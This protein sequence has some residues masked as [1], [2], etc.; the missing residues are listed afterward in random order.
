M[1]TFA[2]G[3]RVI[4]HLRHPRLLLNSALILLL[5]SLLSQAQD[6]AIS[7][8][9]ATAVRLSQ[10][11]LTSNGFTFAD[12]KLPMC[13]ISGP[14]GPCGVEAFQAGEAN[15]DETRYTCMKLDQATYLGHCVNGKLDGL[16]LVIADGS[17]K[18]TKEAYIS[19]FDKGRIAYPALTSFLVGNT[20]FGIEEKQRSSGCVF[21]GKWDRSDERCAL[22]IKIYG[23]DL[24]TESNAQGL[25]DG[26]FRF[27]EY[28]SK[29]YE[30]MQQ[31]H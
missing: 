18:R 10:K 12:W 4:R 15:I 6:K 9:D 24:F 13:Q 11:I 17:A 23:K 21:F 20:N 7:T 30:F 1:A 19:Y 25:R 31:K 3:L 28:R 26:T 16:S 2:P 27:D 22:F 14:E 8:P 29:F 5:A